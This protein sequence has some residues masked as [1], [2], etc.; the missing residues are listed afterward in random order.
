MIFSKNNLPVYFY[1]YAYLSKK[2]LPYYIGKGKDSRAWQKHTNIKRPTSNN[3]IIILED[4]LSELGALALERRMIRWYGRKDQGTGILRNQTD[5]GDGIEGFI[6]SEKSIIKM[7]YSAKKNW[8]D[9]KYHSMMSEIRQNQMTKEIKENISNT[10][11][12]LWQNDEYV[13]NQMISR[14]NSDYIKI[15]SQKAKNRER[16]KCIHCGLLCQKG[17]LSRW[18]ND[19]CKFKSDQ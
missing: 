16:F 6:F 5:G 1:V 12:S 17:H 14:S 7:T 19:N 18:H 15:L 3:Q 2:G 9:E 10:V 13:K 8:S 4:E 11:T